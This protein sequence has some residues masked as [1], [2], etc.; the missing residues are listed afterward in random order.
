MTKVAIVIDNYKLVRFEQGLAGAGYEF[1]KARQSQLPRGMKSLQNASVLVVTT[2]DVEGLQKL[3]KQL[4][5]ECVKGA[6]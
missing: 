6:Q 1:I 3:V 4:N 5:D 2:E